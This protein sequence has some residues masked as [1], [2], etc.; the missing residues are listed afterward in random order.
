MNTSTIS[1][2]W[3]G[4]EHPHLDVS[5]EIAVGSEGPGASDV[6]AGFENV[7]NV[8]SYQLVDLQLQ[9]LRVNSV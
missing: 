7:G 9:P 6:T 8:T 5:Y 2:A 1:A 3:Y 4:F